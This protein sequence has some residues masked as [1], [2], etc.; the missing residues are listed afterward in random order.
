[1]RDRNVTLAAVP[2]FFTREAFDNDLLELFGAQE[3]SSSQLTAELYPLLFCGPTRGYSSRLL[4]RPGLEPGAR[5]AAV[6]CLLEGVR[7]LSRRLGAKLVA[8]GYLP[9]GD[10]KELLAVDARLCA[11]FAESEAVLG[12]LSAYETQVSSK[13]RRES[14]RETRRFSAHGLRV[15]RRRLSEVLEP[16]SALVAHHERRFSAD[17]TVDFVIDHYRQRIARGLDP[18]TDVLC[19][20]NDKGALVGA[21][22]LNR[23][24]RTYYARDF[25]ADPEAPRGAAVYFN[26]LF[27]EPARIALEDGLE[28]VHY[29]TRALET[30]I[31]RGCT[32]RP[33]WFVLDP[34]TEWSSERREQLRTRALAAVEREAALLTSCHGEARMRQELELE[35]T[36]A[37]LQ[38]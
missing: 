27:H 30:K 20:W 28:H 29:G 3:A 9:L 25:G 31:H 22:V 4:V 14:R 24:G 11:V 18:I 2:C 12:P 26:L 1:V 35:A 38:A 37:L 32:V 19:A 6:A 17:V 23:H 10:V 7:A 13:L 33:L 16:L 5:A 21:A 15:E 36:L 8:F 34:S